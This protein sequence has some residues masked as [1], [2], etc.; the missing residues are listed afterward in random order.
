MHVAL[1]RPA[2][3]SKGST[4]GVCHYTDQL[5]IDQLRYVTILI[6][7]PWRTRFIWWTP[8][9]RAIK[10]LSRV[11]KSSKLYGAGG[12][13][14]SSP[15]LPP[16]SSSHTQRYVPHFKTM[17]SSLR[18]YP[19]QTVTLDMTDPV[20]P[21]ISRQC[22]GYGEQVSV[23]TSSIVVTSSTP[24]AC[25]SWSGAVLSPWVLRRNGEFLDSSFGTF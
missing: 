16:S 17:F 18:H 1:D 13:L 21:H 25:A 15:H 24:V 4:W 23:I 14:V 10:G 5:L 12:G 7:G 22:R 3:I 6:T 11:E 8:E 9:M 2:E 20:P 19:R